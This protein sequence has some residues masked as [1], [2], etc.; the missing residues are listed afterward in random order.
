MASDELKE[1]C[2]ELADDEAP[3]RHS[4]WTV[5]AALYRLEVGTEP[6]PLDLHKLGCCPRHF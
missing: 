2:C 5:F 1:I 3:E 4:L 6:N